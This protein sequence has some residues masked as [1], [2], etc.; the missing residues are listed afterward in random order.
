MNSVATDGSL[1]SPGETPLDRFRALVLADAPLQETLRAC[2]DRHRFIAL[3]VETAREC[4]FELDADGLER[5]L[6]RPLPGIGDPTA[7]VGDAET[8]LPRPGWLPIRAFWRDGELYAHWSYFGEEQ[9]R[10]PFFEGDVQRALGRPFNQL[11]RHVTPIER[12]ADWPPAKAGPPPSGLIFHMSRCGST[13]VTQMLAALDQNIVIS[14]ANPVDAVVQARHVRPDLTAEE[15]ARWLRWMVSAL[16]A[17][18]AGG[19]YAFIKLDCW[20]SLSLPLF[21]LA[22]PDVPWV[23][24]YRDPVEVLVS[25]RTMP[26]SQMIPGLLGP[27]LTTLGL[28]YD[29]ARPEDYYARVLAN[30]C[31]PALRHYS[32]GRALLINYRQLPAALW[33]AILPHFGVAVSESDRAAMAAAA[34]YDAKAPSFEFSGD[35]EAKQ[36]AATAAT[37]AAAAEWLGDFYTRLEALR[38]ADARSA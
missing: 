38:R 35:S 28:G 18:R 10:E 34:R 21:R 33:T 4:G 11:F 8:P 23:F 31:G 24:L 2:H 32:S 37:R 9:L 3:V 1:V 27:D 17:P 20:H 14:E 19:R 5:S 22:F 15:Q 26:G 16:V 25:Q 7:D 36:K 29:P 30:I 12:L 13:L 6:R